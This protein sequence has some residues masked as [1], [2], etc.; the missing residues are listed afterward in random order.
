ME[1]IKELLISLQRRHVDYRFWWDDIRTAKLVLAGVGF[2]EQQFPKAGQN[3]HGSGPR[4]FTKLYKI[5]T[6]RDDISMLKV[7]C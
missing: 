6:P 4:I 3:I 2:T 7:Y 1:F 5:T